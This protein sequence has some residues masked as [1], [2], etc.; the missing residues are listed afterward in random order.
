VIDTGG[1]KVFTAEVEEV[2]LGHP[3]VTD[4]VVVGIPHP[5]WGTMVAAVV[6]GR[7]GQEPEPDVLIAHVGAELADYKK[8]RHIVVVDKVMRTIS[9]KPD[10]KWAREVLSGELPQG[11]LGLDERLAGLQRSHNT[12]LSDVHGSG[13]ARGATPAARQLAAFPAGHV[14][15]VLGLLRVLVADAYFPGGWLRSGDIGHLD[16]GGY[17]TV[18]GRLKDIIV[19][20]GE[21]ISAKEVE[22]V[23]L[24]HPAVAEAAL[25]GAPDDR[26]GERAC[27]FVVLRPGASLDLADVRV[28]FAEA[29]LARQKTPERL[30]ITNAL[31]R[32][33]S[34]KVQKF[35]L[36]DLLR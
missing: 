22:D 23:L 4:A 9:G 8:P 1:E 27:A 5:R 14:A 15:G 19:R 13:V 10:L 34:G 35:A 24:S 25:I 36:R 29:G 2:L 12:L 18:T 28:H 33:A 21:K 26:Y 7:P 11:L 3:A 17:L 31:P 6:S 20:G 30:V 16:S 32:T